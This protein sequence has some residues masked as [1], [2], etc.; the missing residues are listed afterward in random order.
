VEADPVEVEPLEA[1]PV[2][3]ELVERAACVCNIIPKIIIHIFFLFNFIFLFLT[4]F[5]YKFL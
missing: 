5:Y 2:E 3:V 1:E 4:N